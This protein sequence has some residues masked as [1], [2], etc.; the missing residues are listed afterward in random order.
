[1]FAQRTLSAAGLASTLLVALLA[2]PAAAYKE[3]R[4]T[5]TTGPHSLQ[6][7]STTAGAT[8]VYGKNNQYNEWRLRH[9]WVEPPLMKAVSG[10]GAEKV[11]WR[12]TVQRRHGTEG[13]NG[14]WADRYTSPNYSATTDS[15]HN[16]TFTR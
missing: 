3:V 16:A 4:H 8:C 13:G 5:G 6:D 7:N 9:I 1:M 10:M 11:A 15:S 14:P 2:Q 12:F